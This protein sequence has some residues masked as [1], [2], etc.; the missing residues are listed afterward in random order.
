MKLIYR[1]KPPCPKCPYRLGQVQALVNPCSQCK[2]DGYSM[3]G[4]FRQSFLRVGRNTTKGGD[5]S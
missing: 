2:K 3:F 1:I 4:C 5:A